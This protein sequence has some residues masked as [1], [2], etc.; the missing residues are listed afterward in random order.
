MVASG[1]QN[2]QRCFLSPL[3]NQSIL[4]HCWGYVQ[5]PTQQGAR[6]FIPFGMSGLATMGVLGER[7]YRSLGWE[8]MGG[9]KSMN[10]REMKLRSAIGGGRL[11]F[12]QLSVS[13]PMFLT[14]F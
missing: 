7:C 3:P 13:M 1:R 10:A 9:D 14:H 12:I 4:V 6:G 5:T 11:R 8:D 2:E